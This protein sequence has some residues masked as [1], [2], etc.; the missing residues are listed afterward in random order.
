M[1]SLKLSAEDFAPAPPASDAERIA[2]RRSP[3]GKTP[4][5]G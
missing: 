4:G 3:T 1:T 5:N 2:A